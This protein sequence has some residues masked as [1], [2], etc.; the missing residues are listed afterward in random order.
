MIGY[1]FSFYFSIL[2]VLKILNA[3]NKI[4]IYFVLFGIVMNILIPDGFS[5][6]IGV[7][8]S[9]CRRYYH[10][11]A[12]SASILP[13]FIVAFPS[14][15]TY[16]IKKL[17]NKLGCSAGCSWGAMLLS[18]AFLGEAH[19]HSFHTFIVYFYQ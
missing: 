19:D 6:S 12:L 1:T 8:Y 17:L 3:M 9:F 4:E 13:G 15:L 14:I 10:T 2:E 16:P 18:L 5:T 11:S 7:L